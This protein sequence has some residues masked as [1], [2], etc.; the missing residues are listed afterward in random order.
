LAPNNDSGTRTI[1]KNERILKE[2]R[3][4]WR[5]AHAARAAFLIDADAYYG[6]FVEAV[7]RARKTIHI[8]GWDMDSR[9]RLR[10]R[11]EPGLELGSF[12]NSVVAARPDLHVYLLSWDYSVIFA[13]ERERLPTVRLGLRTHRR[14][15]F[16]LDGMH[17]PGA[18]H[19]QKIVVIDDQIAFSGG[20]D[21]AIRRWDTPAHPAADPDR[22][23]PAGV[24]YAPFHDAQMLVD[25]EA[26]AIL[27][28]LA[29]ERWYRAT[30]TRLAPPVAGTTDAWPPSVR[31][32]V[33][34]VDVGIARTEPAYNG[35]TGIGEVKQLYL[36]AIASAQDH[37]YIENQYFT[38][39]IIGDALM[40]RLREPHGPE[41]VIVLPRETPGW[42]QERT[43][44]ALRTALV[45]RLR[46]AD[47][48]DRLRVFYP[49]VP[50]LVQGE[51]VKVHSKILIVDDRFVRIA[52]S[53]LNN[54]S[55]GLDTECDLA[56]EADGDARVARAIGAL[57]NR[58]LGE[59]LG[60]AAPIVARL[61][62]RTGSLVAAIEALRTGARTLATLNGPVISPLAHITDAAILDPDGPVRAEK[63][64]QEFVPPPVREKVNHRVARN[65]FLLIGSLLLAAAW[66]W[67]PLR[68]WFDVGTL[69]AWTY[70]I[71]AHP[72]APL[73]ILGA[74]V[75]GGL[76]SFPVT[77]LIVATALSF[78]PGTGFVY[79]LLGSLLSAAVT[80]G[81]GRLLGPE[82]VERWSGPRLKRLQGHLRRRGLTTMVTVHMV[83]IAPFT[84]T[85]ILAG[86]LRVRLRDHLGGAAIGM[87]PGILAITFFTDGLLHALLHPSLRSFAALAALAAVIAWLALRLRRWLATR[88]ALQ[89][90]QRT[91]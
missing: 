50:G 51:C 14:I 37:I 54:R 85:N 89:A 72:A 8:L 48:D 68:E 69:R 84:L 49:I 43:M 75:I 41:I 19:H 11:E 23:D 61:H 46:A 87:T 58:L 57:R 90:Q 55:M 64:V 22:V 83:P 82:V 47:R 27:G 18:S 67:T 80:H 77:L 1:L 78:G 81:V 73:I 21:F 91:L 65:L 4:C 7:R 30:G 25:G 33:K 88:T 9:V 66:M 3:N 42:V 6:A 16:R 32:A 24:P 76:M 86:A 2:G 62:A 34:N 28:E 45:E 10:P 39:D 38:A 56:L 74:F 12:L 63:L 15:H 5:I 26:A 35:L 31:P 44:G 13:M 53:N 17:P 20:L 29:R 52:S 70:A 79:A 36:D 60:V 59:H 40:A 71:S